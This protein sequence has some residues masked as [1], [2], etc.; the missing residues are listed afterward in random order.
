VHDDAIEM[1]TRRAFCGALGV[2][3][4]ATEA[5]AARAG[6]NISSERAPRLTEAEFRSL[7]QKVRNWGRWGAEDALGALNLITPS[8]ILRA[9]ALIREGV[10]VHCGG[11]VPALIPGSMDKTG[12]LSLRI[13]A[14]DD[15]GAVND[16]VTLDVHG[17]P[18]LT[19][20]DALGHI[21]Y[22]GRQYNDRPF[23]GVLGDSVKE[24]SIGEAREGITSRGVYINLAKAAGKPW[25]EPDDR[26]SPK[27]F[28]RA[29]EASG[30]QL[31]AGDILFLDTGVDALRNARSIGPGGAAITGTLQLECAEMLHEVGVSVIVGDGGTDSLP[32][33]VQ[34]VRI[35]WHI[36]CIVEM[37][38]RLVDCADLSRLATACERFKRNTFFCIIA[39]IDYPGA[40]S[41]P[42]NPICVF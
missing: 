16:T 30:V 11:P 3:I 10:T 41:S 6:T 34:S 39:P 28:Q 9:K 35:P 40:T 20:L 24:H 7:G 26:L 2:A 1:L 23:R 22:R 21:Y 17:H 29:L 4:A 5:G 19:H 18:G 8:T 31:A 27:Q 12:S 42:V 25:L 36:L 14:A 13:E 38:V 15:W 32:S 33:E 37:G